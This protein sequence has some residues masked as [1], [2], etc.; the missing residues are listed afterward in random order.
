VIEHRR[1]RIL[2]CNALAIPQRNGCSNNYVKH[3][4]KLGRIAT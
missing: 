3:F 2:H 4:Q 1:R